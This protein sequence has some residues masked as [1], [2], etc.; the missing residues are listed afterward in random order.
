MLKIGKI[1]PK[2][3]LF[4]FV[5]FS[6]QLLGCGEDSDDNDLN[7]DISA[8]PLPPDESM[9]VDLSAFGVESVNPIPQANN[10]SAPGK[11]YANAVLRATAINT[12][13]IAA[14]ATPT[15]LF[16]LAKNSEPVEQKDGSWLWSYNMKYG[17]YTLNA[18]LSG[19]VNGK[20]TYW[21]MKV[22]NDSPGLKI[23]DFEWYAGIS[24]ENN[25]SGSWQ[26]FDL[27]TPEE[28]NPTVKID[29]VMQ[30]VLKKAELNL[31]N[32][33]N[34]SEYLGDVLTYNATPETASMVYHDI[35][36][37]ENW[38]ITWDT[39]TGTGSLKVPKYNNGE[40]ACWDAQKQ[41]VKCN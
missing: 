11:N 28:H 34:L 41:D 21:S 40:K 18:N 23:K 32:V 6:I 37:K 38:D 13:I 14:L 4:I 35:S 33:D 2:L 16:K 24:M 1:L 3:L 30:L 15:A 5:I 36:E 29:W 7:M 20:K 27:N 9:E 26:F 8:P 25:T 17:V 31:E 22:S 10:I 19:V 12:S 39:K